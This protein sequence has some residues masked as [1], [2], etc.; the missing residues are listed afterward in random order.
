M[1]TTIISDS[2]RIYVGTYHKYASGSIYGEWVDLTAFADSSEFVTYCQQLHKSE[3][4][5]EFMIQDFENFPNF[6]YQESG[7]P[8]EET[9]NAI[10]EYAEMDNKEEFEAFLSLREYSLSDDWDE[11]KSDFEDQK[12]GEFESENDFA[13]HYV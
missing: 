12:Q 8:S 9:F 1:S 11:I 3:Y 7:L 2:P 10:R 6:F 4:D 13:Y 5:P